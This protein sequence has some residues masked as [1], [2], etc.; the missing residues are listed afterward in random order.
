MSSTLS[1]ALRGKFIELRRESHTN[2]FLP[3]STLD[4]QSPISDG[5]ER[6]GRRLFRGDYPNPSSG[7]NHL[8]P[9]DYPV[10]DGLQ[11]VAYS[12]FTYSGDRK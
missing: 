10:L 6:I 1:A 2:E 9:G 8:F 11:I 12:L 5:E 7:D 3:C 4:N